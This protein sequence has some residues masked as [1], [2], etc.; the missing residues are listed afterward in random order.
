MQQN[1]I[2]TD[3][4]GLAF[5]SKYGKP[6]KNKPIVR[7]GNDSLDR[8]VTAGQAVAPNSRGDFATTKK[9]T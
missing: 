7:D 3:T 4:N 2:W 8:W 6:N 9:L 5:V 1:A